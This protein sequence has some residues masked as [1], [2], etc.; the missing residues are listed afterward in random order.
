MASKPQPSTCLP[1][2]AW[3][4]YEHLLT[5]PASCVGLGDTQVPMFVIQEITFLRGLGYP[6]PSL[7]LLS[8]WI[9]LNC[10]ITDSKVVHNIP[11]LLLKQLQNL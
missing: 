2:W 5:C 8:N 1:P 6:L 10:D 7:W 11:L 3:D 4:D 9:I